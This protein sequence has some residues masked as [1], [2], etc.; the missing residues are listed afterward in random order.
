VGSVTGSIVARDI[1]YGTG[2]ALALA[3]IHGCKELKNQPG[4]P[5]TE[6]D[7]RVIA[8]LVVKTLEVISRYM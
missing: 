6:G 1:G 4:T 3:P 8:V 2:T 7:P 5:L